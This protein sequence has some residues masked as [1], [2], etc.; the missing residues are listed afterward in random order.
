M[1]SHNTLRLRHGVS[2]LV[3][4][5]SIA[6]G[7]RNWSQVLLQTQSV[8]HDNSHNFGENLGFAFF[9]PPQSVCSSASQDQSLCFRCSQVVE[10]WYN[11][12]SNYNF[13]EGIP[14]N[15]SQPWL[16]FT[17]VVWRGSL[18]FGV[19]VASGGL[20]HYVVARYSPRGNIGGPDG[21]LRNVLPI[22]PGLSTKL[23]CNRA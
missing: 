17:Q 11:E 18:E 13:S 7:A 15:A 20:S 10:A 9:R 23:L 2:S 3:W 16:H 12:I 5:E 6:T 8:R 19:G 22:Q 21:F 4:S 1:D 14:I